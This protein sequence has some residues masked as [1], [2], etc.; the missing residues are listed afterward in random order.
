MVTCRK[1]FKE[2]LCYFDMIDEYDMG[3]SAGVKDECFNWKLRVLQAGLTA[4]IIIGGLCY[5]SSKNDI[6]NLRE[7][8]I[9][10]S[11]SYMFDEN[12]PHKYNPHPSISPGE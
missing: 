12:E 9:S 3:Y 4:T 5:L 10:S 8:G 11:V 7:R 1:V 2:Q 6:G